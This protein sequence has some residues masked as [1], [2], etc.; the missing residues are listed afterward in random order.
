MSAT[1]HKY[2]MELTDN[3][4]SFFQRTGIIVNDEELDWL[5]V[6]SSCFT[7]LFL[8]PEVHAILDFCKNNPEYHIITVTYPGHITLNYLRRR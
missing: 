7:P 5:G 8:E 4:R 3:V 6:N 2:K 1:C